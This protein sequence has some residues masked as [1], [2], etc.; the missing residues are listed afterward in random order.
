MGE[1]GDLH[2]WSILIV[3]RTSNYITWADVAGLI[4]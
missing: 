3:Q 2:A 4:Q 1:V